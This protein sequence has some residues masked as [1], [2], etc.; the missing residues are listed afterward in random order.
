MLLGAFDAIICTHHAHGGKGAVSVF[1]QSVS[2]HKQNNVVAQGAFLELASLF[3]T[4]GISYT[5]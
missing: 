3:Y 1:F 2:F 5:I 4:H